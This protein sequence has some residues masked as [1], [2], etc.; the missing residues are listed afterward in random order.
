MTEII[1]LASATCLLAALF[2]PVLRRSAKRQPTDVLSIDIE[3]DTEPVLAHLREVSAA[4]ERIAQQQ[5]RIGV[6]AVRL[7]VR[8]NPIPQPEP[9]Q[10]GAD[11]RRE[12]RSPRTPAKPQGQRRQR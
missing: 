2:A 9:I 4:L 10:R 3:C 7:E 11:P 1:L 8:D 6:P 5:D 12:P